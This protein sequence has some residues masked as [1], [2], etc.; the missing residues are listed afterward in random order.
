MAD[1][2]SEL[3]KGEVTMFNSVPYTND[4]LTDEVALAML[5]DNPGNE[6]RFVAY[7]KEYK[8]KTEPAKISDVKKSLAKAKEAVS[9]GKAA[10]KKADSDVAAIEG[11][12]VKL[13][14]NVQEAVK[15]EEA[16]DDS[17]KKAA[18]EALK[19]AE[20]IHDKEIEALVVAE[21]KVPKLKDTQEE[22]DADVIKFQALLTERTK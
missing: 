22:N 1:R 8:V 12:I 10:M 6:N 9:K 20:V 14:S 19:D 2:K 5:K 11:N 13:A 4:N 17:D 3:K 21:E 15:A 18:H 7:P 16:A